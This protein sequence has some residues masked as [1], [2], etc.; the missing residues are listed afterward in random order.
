MKKSRAIALLFSR[1]LGVSLTSCICPVR[2]QML[3]LQVHSR[4]C[5]SAEGADSGFR[6]ILAETAG[7]KTESFLFRRRRRNKPKK[8]GV[9]GLRG[10]DLRSKYYPVPLPLFS[11]VHTFVGAQICS[12]GFEPPLGAVAKASGG[13][14]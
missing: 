6:F 7:R 2:G 5:G 8:R 4:S 10:G 14:G 13:W 3:C 1:V 9:K 12:R 11:V